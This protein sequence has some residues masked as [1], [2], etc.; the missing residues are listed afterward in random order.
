MKKPKECKNFANNTCL[1]HLG[2]IQCVNAEV[3]TLKSRIEK[4]AE[5]LPPDAA[6]DFCD[7]VAKSVEQVR[8]NTFK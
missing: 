2:K 5:S 4:T 1:C 6:R 3:A 8:R 7:R